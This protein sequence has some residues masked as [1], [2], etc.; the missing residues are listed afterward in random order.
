M[1][2][3]EPVAE[4]THGSFSIPI[5]KPSAGEGRVGIDGLSLH[6]ATP[7]S[8]DTYMAKADGRRIKDMPM[9]ISAQKGQSTSGNDCSCVVALIALASR[10]L[11]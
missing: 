8:N 5:E 1:Q 4:A 9:K 11:P 10:T 7:I 6:A 3:S 2:L